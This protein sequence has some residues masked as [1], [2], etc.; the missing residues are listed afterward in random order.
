MSISAL[1]SP[2]NDTPDVFRAV[3]QKHFERTLDSMPPCRNPSKDGL[4]THIGE[5]V[6]HL[7]GMVADIAEELVYDNY[8]SQVSGTNLYDGFVEGGNLDD[9]RAGATPFRTHTALG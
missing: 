9:L 5:T 1:L 2:D 8:H 7:Q 4:L 6:L 3:V